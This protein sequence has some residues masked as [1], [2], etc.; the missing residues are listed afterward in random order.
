MAF[1]FEVNEFGEVL[2]QTSLDL[3]PLAQPLHRERCVSCR[4]PQGAC[5]WKVSNLWDDLGWLNSA[6]QDPLKSTILWKYKC[7]LKKEKA[8]HWNRSSCPSKV[9]QIFPISYEV[10]PHSW[11]GKC[12]K[13]S[14]SVSQ[15]SWKQSHPYKQFVC[16]FLGT[17]EN[18]TTG[19][20]KP[21]QLKLGNI[22]HPVISQVF[23]DARN[24]SNKL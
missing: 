10:C 22:S 23:T 7:Q 2:S 8:G 14:L 3:P 18:L 19:V 4:Q 5:V 24:S 16:L 1:S 6:Q 17:L 13:T 12:C 15:V 21:L 11:A 9:R 20:V